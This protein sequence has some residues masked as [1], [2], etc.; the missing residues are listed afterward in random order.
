MKLLL[1][2]FILLLNLPVLPANSGTNPLITWDLTELFHDESKWKES[3]N[4]IEKD[5]A[6]VKICQGKLGNSSGQLLKC[7]TAMYDLRKQTGRAYVWASLQ[8]STDL[9]NTKFNEYNEVMKN[10]SAKVSETMSFV[11]P[12]LIKIGEKKIKSLTNGKKEFAPYSV[13]LQDVIREAK[14]T[15]GAKE[16]ALM[17]AFSPVLGDSSSTRELLYTADMTWEK[18]KLANGETVTVDDNGYSK[19]RAST[20]RND[21][22]KVFASFYTSLKQF[23]RTLGSILSRELQTHVIDAKQR[24]YKTAL[25]RSLSAN[26]VPESV[27]RSLVAEVNT[28]RSRIPRQLPGAGEKWQEI[29]ARRKP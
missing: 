28:K 10:L 3:L 7:L 5:L 4:K 11:R 26:N 16:E 27:Y 13:F 17:A 6:S 29:H 19:H 23:E 15:L 1:P 21:R 24:K 22:I 2:V 12:E 18:V 14:H 8:L 25:E 9:K 20:N